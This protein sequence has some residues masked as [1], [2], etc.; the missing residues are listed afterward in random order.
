MCEI[1]SIHNWRRKNWRHSLRDLILTLS[2]SIQKSLITFEKSIVNSW[3]SANVQTVIILRQQIFFI[4]VE[5]LNIYFS[6]NRRMHSSKVLLY[7]TILTTQVCTALTA[8]NMTNFQHDAE[9][10]DDSKSDTAF[11][12]WAQDSKTQVMNVIDEQLNKRQICIRLSV[13]T[14][15]RNMTEQ[16][17]EDWSHHL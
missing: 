9:N 17:F 5:S 8:L 2:S 15:L 10:K 12:N 3:R 6:E 7:V 11:A 14:M 4:F 1:E 16:V 13:K